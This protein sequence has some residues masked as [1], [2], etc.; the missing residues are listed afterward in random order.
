VAAGASLI[1][2]KETWDLHDWA[3]WTFSALM[4]VTLLICAARVTFRLNGDGVRADRP[5]IAAS[6]HLNG[7]VWASRLSAFAFA[8]LQRSVE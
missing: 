5:E 1:A 7:G 3:A 4:V 8:C 6:I 2:A